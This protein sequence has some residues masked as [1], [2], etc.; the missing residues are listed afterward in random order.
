MKLRTL[1]G[2]RI[3]LLI[4]IS[5]FT[6][7][8]CDDDSSSDSADS[9]YVSDDTSDSSDDTTDS[10]DDTSDSSD[11]S[12][13]SDI[14]YSELS[15][16][17][18]WSEATHEKLDTDEIIT[19]LD[20]VFNTNSVQ[21]LRVV[22]ESENWT[23][24]NDE[25]DELSEDLGD[26][27]DFN[28]IDNPSFVPSEVFYSNDDGDSWT[29]WYKVG[30]RFKGNSSLYNANSSKLPFK[31]D[32][33]EFEDE[34]PDIKNQRFYGFKQLNLKNNYEDESEMHEIVANELFR[35]FGLA[36]AH[37]SF[38]ALYL[39]VNDGDEEDDI[40]YGLYTLVEEVDDTVIET[41]Y[42][43]NDDGN[44]Y[45]PEDDA[46]SF[47]D[48]TYDEDEY[49]LKTDDDES[50]ED[51]AELYN[52]INDSSR[53]SDPDTW[54]SD[55]EAIFDVDTFLKWLAAN[56]VMQNWDTY[57]VMTHNFF[58]YNNPTSGTFEWLPWDNNEALVDSNRALSM[59]MDSIVSSDWP[60]IGYILDDDDYQETYQAYIQAFS[61]SYFNDD[62]STGYNVN[63]DFETYQTLIESY[64]NTEGSDY[65]FTSES[66][67][68]S[69]VSELIEHTTERY[70][71]AENYIGW[72]D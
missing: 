1:F 59:K 4:I 19:N 30:V 36:S 42:Y 68:T 46:A 70:N 48:G 18:D 31:L 22:I 39:N 49:G 32:F 67:F 44:L 7:S 43:D 51:I 14:Y 21:K 13:D 53:T 27:T 3:F 34:Y 28:S 8:G 65:T 63:D 50:Y 10:S 11:D 60:L 24:M 61:Q 35:D 71:A 52:I 72:D 9:S 29:E 57:G 66:D 6:I 25:L 12:E 26:S 40:Y 5:I 38:Y 62:A 69:A 23:V 41:Q 17:S 54:K 2:Y 58:L 20:V 64:V 45:K 56:S 37:S 47:A 16:I 55:L 15:D 33:D